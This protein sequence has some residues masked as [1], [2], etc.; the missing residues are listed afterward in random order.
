MS[1]GIPL[2]RVV[3]VLLDSGADGSQTGSGYLVGGRLVLTADHC[4]RDASGQRAGQLRVVRASDGAQATASVLASSDEVDVAV[5]GLPD[6][7]WSAE[8]PAPRYGRV[9]RSRTEELSDCEAVGFPRWQYDQADQGR[10]AAALRGFIRV[11]DD[12][13]SGFLVLRDQPLDTV[14]AHPGTGPGDADAGSPWEGLSG[15]VVFCRGHALG[16]IVEHRREQGAAAI[17]LVPF[18]RV[19]GGL[20]P[21]TRAVAAALGLPAVGQLPIISE[22]GAAALDDLAY[23]LRDG[24]FQVVVSMNAYQLGATG[25]SYGNLH[26]HGRRDPYVPRRIDPQLRAAL[27]PRQLVL[28]TGPSKAGKTRTAFEA[29]VTRWPQARLVVPTVQ[30]LS[31]L[32]G[33][34]QLKDRAEPVV[35]WLNDVQHYLVSMQPLT[36]GLLD[37]LTDSTG[38][39]MVI[40]TLRTEERDRLRQSTGEVTSDVRSVLDAAVTIE[41]A[42]T[43]DDPLEQAAARQAYPDEDLESVGLAEQLANAPALL[44]AYRDARQARPLDYL[45]I[46]I[47]VDCQRVGLPDPLREPLLLGL[48]RKVAWAELTDLRV[49]DEDTADALRR[50]STPLP[51]PG[52]VA[53]LL[54]RPLDDG[55]RGYLAFDYLVAA[56]NGQGGQHRTVPQAFWPQILDE[57]TPEEAQLISLNA[58]LRHEEAAAITAGRVAAQGGNLLAMFVLGVLLTSQDPP[59]LEEAAFWLE[60]GA[61]A[62]DPNAMNNLGWLLAKREPPELD[63]AREWWQKAADAGNTRAMKSLADSLRTQPPKDRERALALY[64]QAGARAAELRDAEAMTETAVTL[65]LQFPGSDDEVRHLLEDAANL[66]N[67]TAMELLGAHLADLNPPELDEARRW[68]R[69]AEKLGSVRATA[70]LGVIAMKEEP[71]DPDKG[72]RLLTQAADQGDVVAMNYLAR[73]EDDP[74]EALKWLGKAADAGDADAMFTLGMEKARGR[75][76]DIPGA[77]QLWEQA[78]ERGHTKA[79]IQLAVLLQNADPPQTDAA[80]DWWRRAADAND[81]EAMAYLGAVQYRK[82]DLAGARHWQELGAEAGNPESMVMLAGMLA[83]GD[84]PDL[85]GSVQWNEKAAELGDTDAMVNLG[86][87][88]AFDC[89]PPDRASGQAWIERAA[90]LGHPT[91]M[92]ILGEMLATG[93]TRD[94]NGTRHWWQQAADRGLPSAQAGL[95]AIAAAE[96]RWRDAVTLLGEAT[97]GGLEHADAYQLAIDED[98]AIRDQASDTLRGLTDDPLVPVFLGLAA[99]RSGDRTRSCE[100]W[101]EAAERDNMVAAVLLKISAS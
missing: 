33:H 95:S 92:Y 31:E 34:P 20:D 62:G 55:V 54:T 25:S 69:Q 80:M 74:A 75:P 18:D 78:A 45:A 26:D 47:A 70:A 85:A 72:R 77:R 66:G 57:V 93:E 96:G 73:F 94:L 52:R 3:A 9:D 1:S 61:R 71:P 88:L 87:E 100:L 79:M 15:A 49:T 7:P 24:D 37:R 16:V 65:K 60:K 10:N 90:R 63:A 40:G 36:L 13:T 17:R 67:V 30:G 91:G 84:P 38:P 4:V 86:V 81:S 50:A 21:G 28:L 56:D 97:T 51:G 29:V 76:Q 14:A 89:E 23:F 101:A 27:E 22:S 68:L 12:A 6:P 59:Q 98:P 46:R 11:T 19:A 39:V 64:R 44:Q 58:V 99:L 43:A 42:T 41:L 2:E 53:P 82:G 35:I 32:A 48:L 83:E 5:L 8:L